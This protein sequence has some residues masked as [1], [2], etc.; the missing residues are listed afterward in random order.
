M[1]A[2]KTRHRL[3]V[4]ITHPIQYF[5][6]V[7]AEL[8]KDPCLEVLVLFGC[9][10]GLR[11]S[12]DPDFGVPIAWDSAPTDG[13]P[14]VLLS[15]CSLADLSHWRTAVPLAVR[16]SWRLRAFRP[17]AVLVFAYTPAF[18][19]ASTLLLWLQGQRLLLRAD[20]TDRAFQRSHL[21]SLFK[22]LLLRG[23]YRQFAHVFPIGSDSDAHFR[24]LGVPDRRR[25]PV[26][27]AV[28]V[29]YFAEQ[30]QHWA[31]QRAPLRQEES[32]PS[33]ALVLLWSAKMTRVKNPEL[34]LESLAL[35]PGE[36][37]QRFW[38]LA[39]GDGPMRNA[40]AVGAEQQL[41]GRCRFV[42][43]R[44]QSELGRFYAMADV[45]VFP[46]QQGETWGL[47]VNEALQFGLAVI[48]SDHVGSGRDLVEPPAQTPM[49][50]ALFASNNPQALAR[51]L[52]AFSEA[53]PEGFVPQPLAELPHP[54]DLAE[55]VGV[56]VHQ[57]VPLSGSARHPAP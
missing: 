29:D 46:S 53:C 35:L 20:G 31:P 8:A 40:F 39:V 26:R 27:Y 6:P 41:P 16:L 14:H 25:T 1:A 43:F 23:W 56:V 57:L 21:K 44:N 3:A 22:D 33:D 37:R 32:I 15:D 49:G 7:F 17:D 48:A 13:F 38:L 28:D 19:T 18:I 54:R 52:V 2:L 4:L 5:R 34:L 9:D 50:S 10:H 30:V 55:A 45:L 11:L 47:V 42:G 51:A 12:L 36:I 24:R